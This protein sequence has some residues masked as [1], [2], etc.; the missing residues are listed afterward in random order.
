MRQFL[1]NLKL[2]FHKSRNLVFVLFVFFMVATLSFF[3]TS[4]TDQSSAVSLSNFNPGNIIS[5]AVMGNYNSMSVSDIQNFL[6]S[7]NP[8]NNTNYDQYLA[9]SRAYPNVTWH[10][11]GEP[12]NGHFVCISEE[13]FG[14]GTSIGSG[15]TAAEI[16]YGAAQEYKINP[17]VLIVLLEKEQ[18]LI[19]DTFPHSGQYRAATGYGCPDTAACDSKYYGLKNQVYNAAWLFRY[20]LDNG[21]YAYPEQTKGVYIA[22]N[23]SA[24][25]GRSEVYI[26][27]RATAALYRYTPYQPNAA[28]LAAGSGYGDSCSAYGNRNFYLFFTSWFGSTQIAVDGDLV[29]IP[30]GEYSFIS[31]LSSSRA[32]GLSDNNAVLVTANDSDRVQKWSLAY[33]SSTGYYTITNVDTNRKLSTNSSTV[34]NGTRIVAASYNAALCSEQ[35]KI[36]RTPDNYLTFESACASGMTIDVDDASQAIGTRLG[37]W[38][39]HGGDNQKWSLHTGATIED[40]VYTVASALDQSKVLDIYEARSAN[41]TNIALWSGQNSINQRWYF[42]YDANTDAYKITNPKTGKVLDLNEALP[43]S[44]ANIQ[45][46]EANGSCAQRWKVQPKTSNQYQILSTCQNGYAISIQGDKAANNVNVQLAVTSNTANQFW[47]IVPLERPLADGVYNVAA[48][49]SQKQVLDVTEGKANDGTNVELYGTNGGSNQKWQFIYNPKTDDYTILSPYSNKALDINEA[50]LRDGSNIHIW[51][52]NDG[53]NQRW[54][55]SKDASGYYSIIS[56]CNAGMSLDANGLS[57]GSNITIW[58][59]HGGNNQKWSL[60]KSD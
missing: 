36:Y 60:T 54:D 14:E 6:T 45:L 57:S 28:A 38:T 44:G 16:I 29:F 26:E 12:Y 40:G 25:C 7:K 17:Q 52:R 47:N 18:G 19:T 2:E 50:I 15:Q 49:S 8:C 53:C 3:A 35:W 10:W 34:N 37:I 41:G 11:S 48:K 22:Y 13:R 32:L 59:A 24:S 20:T 27:N 43:K 9:N 1:T 21:Y 58:T 33:N 46:W 4:H 39:A 5:D 31:K 42:Q 30:D 51:S 55:I 56:A 23:P